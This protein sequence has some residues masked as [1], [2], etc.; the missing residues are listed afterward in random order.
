MTVDLFASVTECGCAAKVPARELSAVLHGLDV[1][2]G[3]AVLVGP[4]TLDDAGVYQLSHE[5]CLVQTVDFFPPVA[6]DP[7][8]YGRIAAANAISDVYAMGGKPLTALA[9]I[10][11]PAELV[12]QGVVGAITR[13]ACEKLR[14]AGCV[15]LGGH[16]IL[17]PQPKFGL[18]VTGVVDPTVMF[19]NAHARPGDVL[20]L[21][22][23][24]G[25]GTTIM[26]IRAG[27]AGAEQERAA[28]RSMATL[29]E[30][31]AELAR[32][33]G[34][35]CATDITGFGLLGHALQLARASGVALEIGVDGLPFLDGALGFAEQGLLSA[36]VYS[37][38]AYAGDSVRFDDDVTLAARDLLFDPQTSGG[39]LICCAPSRAADLVGWARE[40][41]PTASGIIGRV[42]EPAGR[43]R[44]SV[45][46]DACSLAQRTGEPAS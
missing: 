42:V 34:V 23:P 36:A 21:T 39:L 45:R 37:N 3:P 26:A 30:K 32:Q 29:N 7:E 12:S 9:I 11:I 44:I 8:E 28:N 31:A 24:L 15:L 14:E 18:A 41:I 46:R 4:E 25:T 43:T 13:G 27:M 33:C 10:C 40:Q 20:I 16:S 17:D 6:R 35:R 19:T 5:H 1:P 22:K 38:R 2:T